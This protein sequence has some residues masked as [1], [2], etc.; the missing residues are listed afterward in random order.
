M[1]LL[2]A[3]HFDELELEVDG[4]KI[5]LR[6]AAAGGGTRLAVCGTG[7]AGDAPRAP[8]AA[9]AGAGALPAPPADPALSEVSSPL[10][11]TF[12]RAPKPGAPPFV[13]VGASVEPDTVIAIVEVMKLMNTVRAGVRGSVTEILARDG[14][15]VEYGQALMRVRRTG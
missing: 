4:M 14:E 9:P 13:E 15:L 8:A 12:Y 1:R 5:S 3:S 10:L 7:A 11:G 2:E 6:R